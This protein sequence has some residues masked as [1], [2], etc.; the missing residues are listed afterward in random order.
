M[1]AQNDEDYTHLRS[2]NLVIV[3]FCIVCDQFFVWVKKKFNHK[4]CSPTY[5]NYIGEYNETCL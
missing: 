5:D 2:D 1:R 3:L 4:V